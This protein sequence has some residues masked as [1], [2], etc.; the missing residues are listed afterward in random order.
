M[1]DLKRFDNAKQYAAYIGLNP[2][3]YT[4]G[5]SVKGKTRISK[6]GSSALR[7]ALYMPALT[8]MQYN[9]TI[10]L[11]SQRLKQNGKKGKA[12]VCA[13]MRKLIHIIYGVLKS[14]SPFRAADSTTLA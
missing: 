2:K 5:T 3:Q 14:G 1:S 9:P 4:S 7:H 11:F 10:R 12:I 8:A 13:A 6:T